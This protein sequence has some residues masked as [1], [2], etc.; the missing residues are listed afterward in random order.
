MSMCFDIT[1][2]AI[3]TSAPITAVLIPPTQ[4]FLATKFKT[5]QFLG[6][7]HPKP[8]RAMVKGLIRYLVIHKPILS[9]TSRKFTLAYNIAFDV[10][11]IKRMIA[12]VRHIIT[13]DTT[14]QILKTKHLRRC[15]GEEL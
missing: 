4:D 11:K 6:P 2:S 9:L 8:F 10:K 12:R 14:D 7:C 15:S 5:K 13:G 3:F 1:L